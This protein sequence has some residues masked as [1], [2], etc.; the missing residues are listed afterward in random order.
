MDDHLD[1]YA[2]R[3]EQL[4]YDNRSRDRVAVATLEE[5]RY[6]EQLRLQ[7]RAVYQRKAAPPPAMFWSI[8]VD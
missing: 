6:A 2:A 1:V 3:R 8:G 5:I 4:S 7:I